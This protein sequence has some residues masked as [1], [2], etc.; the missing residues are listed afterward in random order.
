MPNIHKHVVWNSN[1]IAVQQQLVANMIALTHAK[2]K[3]VRYEIFLVNA[4][5]FF[6]LLSFTTRSERLFQVN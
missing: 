6:A 3:I 4:S 5:I 1:T 2:R